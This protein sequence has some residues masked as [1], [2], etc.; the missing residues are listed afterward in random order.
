MKA[1]ASSG[2]GELESKISTLESQL[3]AKAE[4]LEGV[5]SSGE[6]YT[7][8]LTARVEAAEAAAATAKADA[9]SAASSASSAAAELE[10]KVAKLQAENKELDGAVEAA[11]EALSSLQAHVR[12][13]SEKA[14]AMLEKEQERVVEHLKSTLEAKVKAAEEKAVAAERE[15]GGCGG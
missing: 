13:N 7:A 14:V 4:E 5:K 11:R 9:D 6:Q 12:E 10:A 8:E 3:A 1:A 2:A 15:G